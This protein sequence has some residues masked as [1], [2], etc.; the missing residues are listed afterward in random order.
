MNNTHLLL[1]FVLMLFCSTGIAQENNSAIHGRIITREGSKE[2]ILIT[3]TTK[4]TYVLSDQ[5][6]YFDLDSQ[7]ND[8]LK[9]TSPFHIEYMYVVNEL[10]IKRNPVLFPIE[11]LYGMNQLNE[12][13]I[14]KYDGGSLGIF[15]GIGKKYTPAERKLRFAKSGVVEPLYNWLSGRTSV[16]KKNLAY[17]REGVRVDKFSDAISSARLTSYFKIPAD[18]TES[19]VYYAVTKE[20]VK[21]ILEASSVDSKALERVVTPIVFE[22]LEMIK[23]D[24]IQ[25]NSSQEG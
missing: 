1:C 9:F 15:D 8:T 24:S 21:D 19:F 11:Q 13:V 23:E 16:L 25:T 17:E 14:T 22:F 12:I 18:Y 7:I 20:E 10:D 5:T 6:G 3:N 4:G 2:G